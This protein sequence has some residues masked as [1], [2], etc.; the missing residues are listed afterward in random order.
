MNEKLWAI[1][2]P[3]P[4]EYHAMPSRDAAELAAHQYNNSGCI[5]HIAE[6]LG[7]ERDVLRVT[8]CEWP[9]DADDHAAELMEVCAP[10]AE[11]AALIFART[12]DASGGEFELA[13]GCV[14]TFYVRAGHDA[15]VESFRVSGAWEPIY[16]VQQ[17]SDGDQHAD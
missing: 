15:P 5:E 4:D 2:V 1:Y 3:G 7:M 16:W 9:G 14:T 12:Y 8:V 6:R 10:D 13:R 11:S 17:T